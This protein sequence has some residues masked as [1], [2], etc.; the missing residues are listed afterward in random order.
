MGRLRQR[1]IRKIPSLPLIHTSMRTTLELGH[2][3]P[4][5]INLQKNLV[6]KS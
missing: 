6:V 4:G 3:L 1:I 2:E 5:R